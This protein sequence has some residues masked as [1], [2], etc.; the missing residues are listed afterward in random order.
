MPSTTGV[1]TGSSVQIAA[2]SYDAAS[3][4]L[5]GVPIVWS[6]G[7]PSVATVN[8]STGLFSALTVGDAIITAT[9][10]NITSTATAHV[11]ASS[12]Y[13]GSW[14]RRTSAANGVGFTVQ[15][16]ILTSYSAGIGITSN[17]CSVSIGDNSYA[18]IDATG[19]FSF[20]WPSGGSVTSQ[21]SGTFTSA[22]TA[23]GFQG[24]GSVN[25]LFCYPNTYVSGSFS[26][27]SWTATRP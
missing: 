26:G 12:I 17:A 16:G 11:G 25:R 27:S 21:A 10:N 20:S 23:T 1:A 4:Q 24:S 15:L 2:T 13:N 8:T 3:H 22:T 14:G 19:H 9:A 5:T 6:S 18:R 7:S